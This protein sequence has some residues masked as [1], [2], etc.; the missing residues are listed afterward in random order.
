MSGVQEYLVSS[1]VQMSLPA[2]ARHRWNLRFAE[3]DP[4]TTGRTW[5]L[6]WH[7][8]DDGVI[9]CESAASSFGSART[10]AVR[11]GELLACRETDLG[12]SCP[13]R[14]VMIEPRHEWHRWWVGEGDAEAFVTLR[15]ELVRRGITLLDV[16]VFDQERHWWCLI[17]PPGSKP[18][19]GSA[20]S[21]FGIPAT[22]LPASP[23]PQGSAMSAR[24]RPRTARPVDAFPHCGR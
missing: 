16:V 21:W 19:S 2:G 18:S 13:D 6:L 4:V 8:D 9:C 11:P 3:L 20:M 5:P 17:D 10:F 14:W 12:Y 1:S 7:L 15:R 24:R 22:S 23:G